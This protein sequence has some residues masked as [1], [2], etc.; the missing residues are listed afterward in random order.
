MGVLKKKF[1]SV[2]K[3]PDW[4]FVLPALLM[5][6]IFKCFFRFELIDKNGSVER[7]RGYIG[8]AWHNRLLFFAPAFPR[9]IRKRSVAV[10]SA[11]RDGQYVSDFIKCFGIGSLR[12]SSSKKGV[13]ALLGAI[14]AIKEGK[15]VVFTPDGPRGPRYVLKPGPVMLAS[16]TGAPVVPLAINASRYWSVKSWD[17]FQ[18]PKPFAKLTMIIGDPIMV[19]P[20]LDADGI[21]KWRKIIEDSMNTINQD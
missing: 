10:V 18:I 11:S 8:M 15:N 19:P 6:F 4:I 9:R 13:N 7:A 3:L 21:E 20:D 2:K 12:G 14:H 5:K 16:K 1:R 17:G